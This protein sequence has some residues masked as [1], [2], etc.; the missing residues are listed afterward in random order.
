MNRPPNLLIIESFHAF[1]VDVEY[2][3]QGHAK[4][5]GAL[6]S[7]IGSFNERHKGRFWSLVSVDDN[8]GVYSQQCL[9]TIIDLFYWKNHI[10]VVDSTFVRR[11]EEFR[12]KFEDRR[13]H[14]RS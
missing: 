11:L 5:L 4:T 1:A 7:C 6:H 3:L 2:C 9:A 12:N 8:D 10:R 13:D 14:L